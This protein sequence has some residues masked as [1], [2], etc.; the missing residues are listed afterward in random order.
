M[1]YVDAS[2]PPAPAKSTVPTVPDNP[3]A[4]P[5]GSPSEPGPSKPNRGK[6]PGQNGAMGKG[7]RML[8]GNVVNEIKAWQS[9]TPARASAKLRGL[10]IN[11]LAAELLDTCDE[12]FIANCSD[13]L[14]L[15]V[16]TLEPEQFDA[17]LGRL[18][19]QVEAGG[20]AL[21]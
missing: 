18:V 20:Q 11:P 9:F 3:D 1:N 14:A 15:R 13:A 21:R 8:F 12:S 17:E 2:L 10:L 4:E 19:A 6:K 5:D 16:R 7:F